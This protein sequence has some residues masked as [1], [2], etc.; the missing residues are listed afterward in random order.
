AAAGGGLRAHLPQA[1][2]APAPG[3]H[4]RGRPRGAAAGELALRSR[5]GGGVHGARGR[6]LDARLARARG[7]PAAVEPPAAAAGAPGPRG[8]LAPE[9]ERARRPAAG[10]LAG[11]PRPRAAGADPLAPPP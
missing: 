11:A 8:A 6:P 3:G 9:R 4:R 1:R 5:R 10:R 7:L 2:R